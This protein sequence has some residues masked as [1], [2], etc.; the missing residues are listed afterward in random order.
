VHYRALSVPGIM[1]G[2]PTLIC[3][4]GATTTSNT[5][6]SV[7][8]LVDATG[9]RRRIALGD[10]TREWWLGAPP[11]TVCHDCGALT[12]QLHHM[13]CDMEQCPFCLDQRLSCACERA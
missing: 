6:C 12:G 1:A 10:E 2:V 9:R 8:E 11:H 13:G 5:P 3:E 4:C 7:T